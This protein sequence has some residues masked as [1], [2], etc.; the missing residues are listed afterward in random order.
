MSRGA[1]VL[2]LLAVVSCKPKPEPTPAQR[3]F[4]M[5]SPV[6]DTLGAALAAD[7]KAHAE[8]AYKQYLQ[9]TGSKDE[10]ELGRKIGQEVLTHN[11]EALAVTPAQE[12]ELKAAKFNDVENRRKV[13]AAVAR[14]LDTKADVPKICEIALLKV[15]S[16]EWKSGLPLEFAVRILE[17]QTRLLPH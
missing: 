11:S 15:Q 13:N 8:Q 5:F 2:I 4:A 1:V 7:L 12:A 3:G 6:A 14:F 16:G 17:A 10:T 9:E